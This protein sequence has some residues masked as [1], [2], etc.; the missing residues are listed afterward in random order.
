M[1]QA[2]FESNEIAQEDN[3]RLDP[4]KA[5]GKLESQT[6]RG[7]LEHRSPWRI[8]AG[9]SA[10][11]TQKGAEENFWRTTQQPQPILLF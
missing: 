1:L 6:S 9:T 2:R 4:R 8:T 11:P 3:F 7:P 5:L 10:N